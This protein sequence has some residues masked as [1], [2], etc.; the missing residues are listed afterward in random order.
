MGS[1][2][3]F[4]QLIWKWVF[5]TAGKF[6]S[7]KQ[8]IWFWQTRSVF[9]LHSSLHSDVNYRTHAMQ[10]QSLNEALQPIRNGPVMHHRWCWDWNVMVCLVLPGSRLRPWCTHWWLWITSVFQLIHFVTCLENVSLV[11]PLQFLISDLEKEN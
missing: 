7:L 4:Y 11:R 6:S 10:G 3:D 8:Y 5:S 2:S 1:I 9:W